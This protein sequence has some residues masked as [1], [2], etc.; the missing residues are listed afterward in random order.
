MTAEEFKREFYLHASNKVISDCNKINKQLD[1]YA[2]PIN[3]EHII[4]NNDS[5]NI[6]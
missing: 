1:M 6:N 4:N 3:P 2:I 5:R